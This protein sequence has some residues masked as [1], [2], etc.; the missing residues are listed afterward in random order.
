MD[1]HDL[2]LGTK[3]SGGGSPPPKS[4]MVGA[5]QLLVGAQLFAAPHDEQSFLGGL[6]RL[7]SRGSLCE[8]AATKRSRNQRPEALFMQLN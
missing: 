4:H 1:E 2:R 8:Y 5:S 6:I 3:R 7:P